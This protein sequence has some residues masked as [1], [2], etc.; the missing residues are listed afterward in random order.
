MS[1]P[2]TSAI[3]REKKRLPF[4]WGRFG[5]ALD[6]LAELLEPG[7]VLESTAIGVYRDFRE[8]PFGP[9]GAGLT[10]ILVGVSDRRLF[11][12]GTTLKGNPLG[13]HAV[14]WAHLIGFAVESDKKRNVAVSWTGGAVAIDSIAKSAFRDL[15]AAV[16]AHADVR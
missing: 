8:Q 4:G 11:L 6:R 7:E 9:I 3:E 10:N 13:H 14:E 5:K 16:A 1:E 15:V 12:I 2:A